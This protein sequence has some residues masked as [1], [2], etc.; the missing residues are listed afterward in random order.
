MST[1]ALCCLICLRDAVLEASGDELSMLENA[2][3]EEHA[4]SLTEGPN[5]SLSSSAPAPRRSLQAFRVINLNVGGQV[6]TTTLSTLT[7][8]PGS[9]L[10]EMF[11]G[12]TRLPLDRKGRYFIDR[13]GTYF[14]YILEFL[15][16]RKPPSHF[17]QGL[18]QEALF[19]G[20]EPLVKSLEEHPEMY[21]ELLGRQNF[22]AQVPN[23]RE[24]IEL[25]I[26]LAR[27][28][29]VAA[30]QSIVMVCIVKN[31]EDDAECLRAVGNLGSNK[32][33]IVK[34]GPWDP[35][36]TVSDMLRCIEMDLEKQGY[37]VSSQPHVMATG[38][39]SKPCNKFYHLIFSW[40]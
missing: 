40:W 9:K 8:F 21:G 11:H 23:Y 5:C 3:E 24:N 26:H 39:L 30:R 27:A 18:Y 35:S 4:R 19:Y 1:A 17:A 36:P 14:K 38:P 2:S 6:Y 32:E 31:E 12:R 10:A 37:R 7:R 34:F 16:T 25:I 22:L 13:N 15:R 20:I 29:A 33:P 28:D